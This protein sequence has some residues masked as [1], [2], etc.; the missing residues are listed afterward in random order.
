MRELWSWIFADLGPDELPSAEDQR[1]VAVFL[2]AVGVAF[3][4]SFP[5]A[6]WPAESAVVGAGLAVAAVRVWRGAG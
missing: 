6:P 2:G 3:V 4:L 1:I 5:A